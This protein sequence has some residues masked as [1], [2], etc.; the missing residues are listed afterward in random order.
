MIPAR[1]VFPSQIEQDGTINEA[2]PASNFMCSFAG[3]SEA[4][5]TNDLIPAE[6]R[7]AI[8]LGKARKT[9]HILH[10]KLL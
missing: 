6:P 9:N 1:S 10:V 7:P 5:P 8:Q 2:T 4:T 3:S